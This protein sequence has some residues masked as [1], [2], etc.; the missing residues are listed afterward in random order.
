MS[1]SIG[2][3]ETCLGRDYSLSQLLHAAKMKLQDDERYVSHRCR[4]V[5]CQISEARL[6]RGATPMNQA[7]VNEKPKRGLWIHA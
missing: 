2:D 5:S 4:D 1:T 3:S 6:S 7:E